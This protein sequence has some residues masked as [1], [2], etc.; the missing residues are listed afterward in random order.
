MIGALR[1]QPVDEGIID[2]IGR[3]YRLG[4]SLR[5]VLVEIK[6]G[7]PEREIEISHDRVELQVARDGKGDVVSDGGGAHAAFGSNDRDDT[8]DRLG[9]RRRKQTAHGTHYLERAD[10]RYQIIAD[11]APHQFAIEPDIVH[12]PNDDDP[13]S[14]VTDRCQLIEA[15]EDI[16]VAA[17][18]FENNDIRRRRALDKLR[19][20]RPARPSECADALWPCADLLRPPGSQRRSPRFHRKPAPK[21]AAPARCAHRGRQPRRQE[22]ST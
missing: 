7:S 6:A 16:L 8:A 3:K 4:N 13:R 21:R 9:V 17:F 10:R 11:T 12:T 22:L 1:E 14:G 18:G 19:W 5:R 2:A 20:R 15:A